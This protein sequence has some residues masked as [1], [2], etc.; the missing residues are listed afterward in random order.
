MR[1]GAP[2]RRAAR[3]SRII[4]IRTRLA[5]QADTGSDYIA[6]EY[7]ARIAGF[8]AVRAATCP[9]YRMFNDLRFCLLDDLVVGHDY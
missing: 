6:I 3:R 1:P 2:P 4:T 7:D 5:V 8:A 9:P